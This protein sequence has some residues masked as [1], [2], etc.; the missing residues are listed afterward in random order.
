MIGRLD[1]TATTNSIPLPAGEVAIFLLTVLIL[2]AL[3]AVLL[4]QARN[5]RAQR[6]GPNS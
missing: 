5:R 6:R 1:I 2:V 4:V 3:V